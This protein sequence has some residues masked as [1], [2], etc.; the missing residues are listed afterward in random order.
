M[1][2]SLVAQTIQPPQIPSN[3]ANGR[4]PLRAVLKDPIHVVLVHGF[5]DNSTSTTGWCPT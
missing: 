3:G 4:D 5:P 1:S 2:L